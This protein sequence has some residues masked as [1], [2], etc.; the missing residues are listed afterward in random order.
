MRE[1]RRPAV[2]RRR[3]SIALESTGHQVRERE[4]DHLCNFMDCVEMLAGVAQ[5]EVHVAEAEAASVVLSPS[6]EEVDLLSSGVYLSSW[7]NSIHERWSDKKHVPL[8]QDRLTMEIASKIGVLEPIVLKQGHLL[9][10]PRHNLFKKK[11]A[12]ISKFSFRI[13]AFVASGFNWDKLKPKDDD[14][15]DDDDDDEEEDSDSE[16][17]DDPDEEINIKRREEQRAKEAARLQALTRGNVRSKQELEKDLIQLAAS[18]SKKMLT[19]RFARS[20][21]VAA[22]GLVGNQSNG[23]SGHTI[24]EIVEK[25]QAVHYE[26]TGRRR[27]L[28]ASLKEERL[29]NFCFVSIKEVNDQ[30][31]MQIWGKRPKNDDWSRYPPKY[32]F[33]VTAIQL[34]EVK[35]YSKKLLVHIRGADAINRL[36]Q[37]IK[38]KM[39]SV[40]ARNQWVHAIE[41]AVAL[42]YMVFLQLMTVKPMEPASRLMIMNSKLVRDEM[43]EKVTP[44]LL[45]LVGQSRLKLD[46][47]QF[48]LEAI[49]AAFM[50][51]LPACPYRQRENVCMYGPLYD[52]AMDVVMHHGQT[53]SL[54]LRQLAY[55]MACYFRQIG[56]DATAQMLSL[57]VALDVVHTSHIDV[58]TV[59]EALTA[60]AGI[61][62]TRGEDE[63]A[64]KLL[65]Q[66]DHL[67][68]QLIMLKPKELGLATHRA[69][70]RYDIS[71][72]LRQTFSFESAEKV[73]LGCIQD[74]ERDLGPMCVEM[75]EPMLQLAEMLVFKEHQ[76]QAYR[77]LQR[78][79]KSIRAR[80]GDDMESSDAVMQWVALYQT[81]SAVLVLSGQLGVGLEIL[82][83][84]IGIAVSSFGVNS[85]ATARL[86]IRMG[87]AVFQVDQ[88]M[89]AMYFY[90]EALQVYESQSY[91]DVVMM[92]PAIRRLAGLYLLIGRQDMALDLFE[93]QYALIVNEFGVHAPRARAI[94]LMVKM[95]EKANGLE[96]NGYLGR[97]DPGLIFVMSQLVENWEGEGESTQTVAELSKLAHKHYLRAECAEATE[98]QLRVIEEIRDQL[99]NAHPL[100]GQELKFLGSIYQKWGKF[101]HAL[102]A[103]EQSYTILSASLGKDHPQVAHALVYQAVLMHGTGNFEASVDLSERAMTTLSTYMHHEHPSIIAVVRLAGQAHL[104]CKNYDRAVELLTWFTDSQTSKDKLALRSNLVTA[105]AYITTA[106][107]LAVQED[108]VSAR[109]CAAIGNALQMQELGKMHYSSKRSQNFINRLGV[110]QAWATSSDVMRTAM[111][112]KAIVQAMRV[113]RQ[114]GLFRAISSKKSTNEPNK[115]E[116]GSRKFSQRD[117]E[118]VRR[119]INKQATSAQNRLKSKSMSK[120]HQH[121]V[122]EHANPDDTHVHPVE[123]KRVDHNLTH[124]MQKQ[125][126]RNI[127]GGKGIDTGE[128]FAHDMEG[129]IQRT[130]ELSHYLPI[131]DDLARQTSAIYFKHEGGYTV[132]RHLTVAETLNPEMAEEDMHADLEHDDNLFGALG[133]IASAF[134]E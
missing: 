41:S 49:A 67:L 84:A 122:N 54:V 64:L 13:P 112:E 20:Q 124:L 86:L 34:R 82:D 38:F 118:A 5:D 68:T 100:V 107:V 14:D 110:L 47:S 69:H 90:E 25:K 65:Q 63:V 133:N 119:I 77:L 94:K 51:L 89:D 99:G 114:T 31:K 73:L 109:N 58:R 30:F 70:L 116:M 21:S 102:T 3:P 59:A 123:R 95:C 60:M 127:M 72:K 39:E 115:L 113:S 17:S 134:E 92:D 7:Q 50:N 103:F 36:P 55:Q 40:A 76:K 42:P 104:M 117:A 33:P 132:T 12:K 45:S 24:Q 97:A 2:R 4:L 48:S 128:G 52:R 129:L 11:L 32:S 121:F 35:S 27:K 120:I 61:T 106:Q 108:F 8:N 37:K 44:A 29:W 75:D 71:C 91:T 78:V 80:N 53:D 111:E 79:E 19:P 81:K 18:G 96:V 87:D 88:Y 126:T 9:I 93:K 10:E 26:D 66:A 16:E 56:E 15:D 57:F 85:L 101:I 22:S 43:S 28:Q 46:K 1:R 6:E 131:S 62:T 105:S 23:T 83:R 125:L 74:Y 98:A 130:K